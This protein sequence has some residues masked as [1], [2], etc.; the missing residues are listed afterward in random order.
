MIGE[1]LPF[2]LALVAAFVPVLLWAYAFSYIEAE[3]LS[4]QR[5]FL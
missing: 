1:V 3:H 2:L 4:V 5:F